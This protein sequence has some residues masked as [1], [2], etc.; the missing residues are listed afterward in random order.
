MADY[1]TQFSTMVVATK[2][3]ERN[4]LREEILDRSDYSKHE[5]STL[6]CEWSTQEDGVW[7]RSNESPN[8]EA[9]ASLIH[10]FLKKF[11]RKDAVTIT[12]ASFCSKL[13][14]DE[15]TG[16]GIFITAEGTSWF[17]PDDFFSAERKKMMDRRLEAKAERKGSRQR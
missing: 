11:N 13:R 17:T 9:V 1:F 7:L 14:V 2:A 12:W 3:K 16:G 10:D 5:D 15:Q 8:L 4:W 6:D